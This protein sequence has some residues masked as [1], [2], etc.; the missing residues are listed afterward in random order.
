MAWFSTW[1]GLP[2]IHPMGLPEKTSLIFLG[3]EDAG[4]QS[5]QSA[6]DAVHAEGVERIVVAELAS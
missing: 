2:S 6:A 4:E 5:A 1:P 3:G